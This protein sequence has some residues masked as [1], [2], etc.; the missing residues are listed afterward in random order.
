MRIRIRIE[1]MA[2]HHREPH[3]RLKAWREARGYSQK[4]AAELAGI[5]QG[6]WSFLERGERLPSLQ[7]AFRLEALT[8]GAVKAPDWLAP[9]D[10]APTG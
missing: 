10:L 7:Q 3:L 4:R 8:D 9:S 1:V 2:R 5:G 6:S